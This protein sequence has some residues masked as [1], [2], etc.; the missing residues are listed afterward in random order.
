MSDMKIWSTMRKQ[1]AMREIV[2]EIVAP[3]L[4][5]RT[6]R[7]VKVEPAKDGKY[8]ALKMVFENE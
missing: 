5:E 1:S 6:T 7:P 2:L 4:L 8:R 3:E